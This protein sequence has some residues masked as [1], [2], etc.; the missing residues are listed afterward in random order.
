[1]APITNRAPKE[2]KLIMHQF[3]RNKVIYPIRIFPFVK[4]PCWELRTDETTVYVLIQF[5]T[6]EALGELEQFLYWKNE[7]PLIIQ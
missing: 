3:G 6:P 1:M 2:F 4:Y 7:E 5:F